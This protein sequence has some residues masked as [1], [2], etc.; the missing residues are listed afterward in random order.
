MKKNSIIS[1]IRSRYLSITIITFMALVFALVA[2]IFKSSSVLNVTP[3]MRPFGELVTNV[4]YSV[5]AAYVFFIYQIVLP[6]IEKSRQLDSYICK[7]VSSLTEIFDDMENCFTLI[8]GTIKY[9]KDKKESTLIY[10]R[11]MAD[12]AAQSQKLEAK[13]TELISINDLYLPKNYT[14]AL[15]SIFRTQFFKMAESYGELLACG[16]NAEINVLQYI[17]RLR[18]EEYRDKAFSEW[19]TLETELK[20]DF[21]CFHKGF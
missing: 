10:V 16:F 21:E 6:E 14:V 5:I 7:Q 17:D 2:A 19:E 20:R 3:H 8:E 11:T 13:I 9:E 15:V 12:I 4:C 18:D 1:I